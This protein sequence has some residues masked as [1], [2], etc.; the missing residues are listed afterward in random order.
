[1][2]FTVGHEYRIIPIGEE[3]VIINDRIGDEYT[4]ATVEINK[5]SAVVI[6]EVIVAHVEFWCVLDDSVDGWGRCWIEIEK[7]IVNETVAEH[8][9]G[10]IALTSWYVSIM[11]MNKIIKIDAT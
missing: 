7:A 11:N 1:M 10:W 6:G 8:V 5:H 4:T 9:E 2:K 3:H